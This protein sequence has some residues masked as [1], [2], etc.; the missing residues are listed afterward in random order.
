MERVQRQAS[1]KITCYRK[2]HLSGDL[3]EH[4]S[5]KVAETV[6]N[7][8]S[9]CKNPNTS[10]GEKHETRGGARQIQYRFRS[11]STSGLETGA[12][13]RH[14]RA[15]TSSS[16]S[17]NAIA[18]C[19]K[20][21]PQTIDRTHTTT[22]SA[23]DNVTIAHAQ[24]GQHG[25]TNQQNNV[26]SQQH[27]G[28]G[29]HENEQQRQV[30]SVTAVSPGANTMSEELKNKLEE[31]RKESLRLEKEMEEMELRAQIE[32]EE[33]KHQERKA[34]MEKLQ[35]AREEANKKHDERMNTIK[36]MEPEKSADDEEYVTWL[37]KKY[38]DM[39]KGMGIAKKREEE[40]RKAVE[41][42]EALL[43]KQK[44]LVAQA[45]SIKSQVADISPELAAL[46]SAINTS[47]KKPEVAEPTEQ[48]NQAKM[49]EYLRS[50][51]SNT[52]NSL[53]GDWQKEAVKQF[54]I[55]SSKTTGIGG[56]TTLKPEILNRLTGTEED[57]SMA[58]WL[59]TLNRQEQG[60]G[61]CFNDEEE[62]RH[63]KI[64]SGILDKATNNIVHKEV[65]PQKN[66]LEDWADEDIEFKHIMFEHMVAGEVRTIETCTEPAQILGRL[67]LLRRLAY[68]KLRGYEWH[69]I[70]KMYSA[71]VRSIETKEYSWED[72]F[73]RFEC[74]LYRRPPMATRSRDQRA[75]RE[76]T[77][78]KWFC[79][80]WNKP[81]GCTKTAPHKAWFG[82]GPGAI[83]RT[84]VH[85][86][87][88]CYLKE[89][90]QKDHPE[91][92]DNCPHKQA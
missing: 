78:K 76:N 47:I 10:R 8:E 3:S 22:S 12:I 67:R 1:K 18:Y 29:A 44:D 35:T 63:K 24:L 72:N 62:C 31:K 88:V 42:A 79:R 61:T 65:W 11:K 54:L 19:S 16:Y 26:D 81:E 59:A 38:E 53:T 17:V 9:P 92:S 68:A 58:N 46:L 57:F 80:D 7:F 43:E 55:N 14:T 75:D 39:S 56:A 48:G 69:L 15:H 64:R 45:E 5:G 20:E 6:S 90:T 30:Q 70:R 85:M 36:T 28:R 77:Q 91:C 2:F 60:E 87:A 51:L 84:V 49:M 37:K 13:I 82:T 50:A 89:R 41:K 52:D 86:C 83:S 32:R 73:D 21:A 27:Q 66:L 33:Q 23:R 25:K 4:I 71:I 40:N 34:A 74:I